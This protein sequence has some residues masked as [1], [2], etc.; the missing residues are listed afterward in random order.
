MNRKKGQRPTLSTVLSLQAI[1]LSCTDN[2]EIYLLFISDFKLFFPEIFNISSLDCVDSLIA[3]WND[4]WND[5]KSLWIHYS[6]VLLKPVFLI[7][8][9]LVIYNNDNDMTF[10]PGKLFICAPDLKVRFSPSGRKWHYTGT[11]EQYCKKCLIVPLFNQGRYTE[12]SISIFQCEVST[13]DHEHSSTF[14]TGIP[15]IG[16][17]SWVLL[18]LTPLSQVIWW[19]NEKAPAKKF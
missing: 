4:I 13:R 9:G 11:N 8:F 1:A 2:F 6:L 14:Y 3:C 16:E 10:F 19:R 12:M 7:P 15:F 5:S 18:I 17:I